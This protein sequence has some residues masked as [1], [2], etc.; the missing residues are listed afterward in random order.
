LCI[1]GLGIERSVEH[2]DS[3]A[4]DHSAAQQVSHADRDRSIGPADPRLASGPDGHRRQRRLVP[5]ER[6]V[7]FR[8]V[9]RDDADSGCLYPPWPVRRR[10]S[11]V[12]A[13]LMQASAWPFSRSHSLPALLV[14]QPAAVFAPAG[15]GRWSTRPDGGDRPLSRRRCPDPREE[16]EAER[17]AATWPGCSRSSCRR[18]AGRWGSDGQPGPAWQHFRGPDGNVY[19]LAAN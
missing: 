2:V 11:G 4:A 3:A 1:T 7:R 16:S 18:T 19:E 15:P 8:C 12:A 10:S 13:Q 9:R 6:A 14:L 5:G 17:D